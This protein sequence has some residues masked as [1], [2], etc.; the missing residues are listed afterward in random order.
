LAEPGGPT[1]MLDAIYL[2]EDLLRDARYKR[3]AIVIFSD[4]GDNVS[5]HSHRE[6]K[7]L[8][9]ERDVEVYA[10]GLF[11]APPFGT[12]EE[13]LGKAWLS[14][15]TDC[16]GGRTVAIRRR[17]KV[18]EAAATVSREITKPIRTRLSSCDSQ[19]REMAEDKGPRRLCDRRATPSH[20]LQARVH[21]P[22]KVTPKN[23][24]GKTSQRNAACVAK[25]YHPRTKSRLCPPL[26]AYEL[27]TRHH[28][29]RSLVRTVIFASMRSGE[30][31]LP[32]SQ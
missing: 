13:K 14:Q 6:I 27:K 21:L 11:A 3:R 4:G 16:T 25:Y 7:G 17:E 30:G 28:D 15:I 23:I 9:R 26:V 20:F 24:Q 29:R 1:A 12:I 2:A 10:I 18:S 22:G 31:F 5:H 8:V 32:S 19:R